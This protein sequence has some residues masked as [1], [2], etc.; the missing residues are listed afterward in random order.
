MAKTVTHNENNESFFGEEKL[1]EKA[2]NSSF[3]SL[4]FE[5]LSERKPSDKEAQIFEL[6]L[7]LSID[8]GPDTPSAAKT[9]E[10]AKAGETVSEAVAEGIKQINDTHGGAI[11]P[12]ME[13]LYRIQDTGFRVQGKVKE[14]IRENKKIPGLGH[15]VY[16]DTDPRA[17]L[18]FKKLNE[19][20]LGGEWIKLEQSL[21]E[22]F[23][24]QSGK[25]LP[26][27]IDGA[28]A[29]CLCTF[30]WDPGL[31][32]AVFII[33]RTPGLCGQY[34]NNKGIPLL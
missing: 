16:K 2:Q 4:I 3:T 20:G 10:A 32:K 5:L 22:E 25:H 30:G 12:A 31:G 18:I 14:Y 28:I 24:K 21:Q 23:E 8:H 29:A 1:M 33:A 26:I 6:V 15:R 7:N 11:E 17:E 19:T 9:R 13:I 34:L 27:N